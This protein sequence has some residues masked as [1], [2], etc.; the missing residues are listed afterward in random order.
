MARTCTVCRH[1]SRRE[2]NRLLVDGRPVRDIAARFQLA[3]SS[4]DRHRR[5]HIP[6]IVAKAKEARDAKEG[7]SL[8]EQLR[9]ITAATREVLAAARGFAENPKPGNCANCVAGPTMTLKAIAR[10]ERQLE[11][12]AR[13]SGQLAAE[14]ET[15]GISSESWKAILTVVTRALEPFPD[16]RQA[17]ADALA[18]YDG[19]TA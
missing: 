4:V 18:E 14:S 9:D 17:V 10:M 19:G 12:Q 3:S 2:I 11:L 8:F 15:P 1:E 6:A 16:A 7:A 5:E 13:L